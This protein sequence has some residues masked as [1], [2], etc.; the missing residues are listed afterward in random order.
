MGVS[1]PD[2]AVT[3]PAAMLFGKMPAHGD[4]VSRGLQAAERDAL[5]LWFSSELAAAR[6]AMGDDFDAAY[7]V[8][9]PWLYAGPADPKCVTWW[10]LA[11]APSI[12][13]AGRRFP[14][15]FGWSGLMP[16]DALPAAEAAGT[17]L[18]DAISE[19]WDVDRLAA[20]PLPDLALGSDP[21]VDDAAA[22]S[23]G[24]RTLDREIAFADAC[25]PGLLTAMLTNTV[26]TP[27]VTA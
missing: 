19:L 1:M 24:W 12:D 23:P 11:M 6:D 4:F 14:L 5:D 25:A 10:A 2:D 3:G 18:F 20:A 13:A 27:M 22:P 7:D 26:P 15:L 9:P 16:T 21:V 17:I 8:A